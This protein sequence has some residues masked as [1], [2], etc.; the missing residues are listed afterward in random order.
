M[1]LSLYGNSSYT[2]FTGEEGDISNLCQYKW[3]ECCYYREERE[4]FSFNPEILGRV[5]GPGTGA[6]NEMSQW[7]L[8][9]KDNVS[10]HQSTRPLHVDKLHSKTE[11]KKRE[12][13]ML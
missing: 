4:Q 12:H 13:S 11:E 3:Y 7:V 6:G 2:A 10:P 5:L 1:F 8:K 9:A